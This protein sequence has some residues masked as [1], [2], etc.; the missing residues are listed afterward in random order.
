MASSA[1]L[2]VPRFLRIPHG[3]FHRPPSL[4]IAFAFFFL[5]SGLGA[6][7]TVVTFDPATTQVTFTL[8]ATMHTVHGSFKLKS[9]EIRFNPSTG[10]ASGSV[11]VDARS[12]DTGNA[13]RDRN[14]HGHVLE[15]AKFPEIIFTP[16][17]L[18][19]SIAPQGISV[20]QLSGRFQLHGQ[21]QPVTLSA[22]V[23][24][25]ASGDP[26]HV[27]TKFPV[28]YVQWGLK[29]PSTFI[30]RVGN[31]VDLEISAEAHVGPGS[32]SQVH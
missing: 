30:L 19:G 13:S 1:G 27:S 9:G 28:P 20:V 17:H 23:E 29:N 12:G 14:M 4:L 24:R 3:F 22:T 18:T 7:Q 26:W 2:T 16:D 5:A 21:E 10:D 11:V 6:Q 15:S 31:T 25:G 32:S 8:G